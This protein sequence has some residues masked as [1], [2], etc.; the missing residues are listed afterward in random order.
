MLIKGTTR[1]FFRRDAQILSVEYGIEEVFVPEARGRDVESA[2][3][4]VGLEVRVDRFGESVAR[5]V[6]IDGKPLDAR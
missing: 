4:R 2:R 6:L 3:D 1:T 5:R